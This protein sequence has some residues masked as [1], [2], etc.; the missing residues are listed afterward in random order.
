MAYKLEDLYKISDE[1]LIEEYDKTAKSTVMGLNYYRDELIRRSGQ[2]VNEAV[3]E[4][5]KIVEKETLVISKMTKVMMW[6]TIVNV[7]L[8]IGNLVIAI[9]FNLN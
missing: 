2:M 1:K 6:F 7:A 9:V 5:S 8:T 4:S 3:I